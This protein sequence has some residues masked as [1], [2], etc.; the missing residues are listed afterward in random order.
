VK[1]T[2]EMYEAFNGAYDREGQHSRGVTAGLA[3]VFEL[4]ENSPVAI[5]PVS[6]ELF[7][8][9]KQDVV[10]LRVLERYALKDAVLY[11]AI[12]EAKAGMNRDQ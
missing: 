10:T 8:S 5:V 1:I 12:N 2:D 3:A 6:R 9:M 7:D 4:I 11:S